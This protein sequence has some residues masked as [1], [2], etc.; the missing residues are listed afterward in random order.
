MSRAPF[1]ADS[2]SSTLSPPSAT[3]QKLQLST[4]GNTKDKK[5]Q[6]QVQ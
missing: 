1:T 4:K 2:L 5:W 3:I 6:V